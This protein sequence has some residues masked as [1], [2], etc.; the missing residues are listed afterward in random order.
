MGAGGRRRPRLRARATWPSGATGPTGRT[1]HR[2]A[3][4]V[5]A[6]DIRRVASAYL[7]EDGLTVGWSLPRRDGPVDGRPAR[8]DPH[9]GGDAAARPRRRSGRLAIEVPRGA[10]TL[11]DFRPRRSMLANGMRLLTERR[12]G[13]GVVALEL[14]VDAGQIRE[15]KPGLA[16]LTGRL[17]EEGTRPAT[18]DELAEA[19][20][21]AGGTL[22]VGPTGASLRVRAEDLDAGHR[23][24]RRPG[25]PARPSPTTRS[26]GSRRKV[27]AEYQ[28]DRDDPAFQADALFRSLV[29]GDHPLG[30]DPRGAARDIGR[31]GRDDVVDHHARYFV[32]GNAFLVAVGDFDPKA[33]GPAGQAPV[34]GLVGR[35]AAAAPTLPK[36]VRSPRPRVR[37]VAQAG[38]AGPPPARPPGGRPDH[39]DFD[40]L[41]RPRLHPRH[42]PGLH[43]PP[44]PGDPRRAG[45]GLLGRRRDDR[46][47]RP[48]AGALP[49]LRRHRPRRGRSRRRGRPGAGPRD[50]RGG[51]LR[52][53]GRDARRYL[54]GS[55]VFDFQ[56]V[57]QRAGRLLELE[58]WGLPLDEP[59]TWPGGSRRS[60]RARSAG[61][62][63]STSTPT[64]LVRV[65]YGPIRRG[66]QGTDAECA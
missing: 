34:R 32:P 11:V 35:G 65:E 53:G 42:G 5:E 33:L 27:A 15:A 14:Y 18:A 49:D 12:E 24:A 20:E 10:P 9:P 22:D 39:P 55:W 61:R 19:V 57:E 13:E 48:P 66:R 29:Y 60:P 36:L 26:N 45:P 16:Y 64:A 43:R 25:D 56:T 37:R 59:L 1:L 52:R 44:E 63:G 6:D 17:L 58:R 47:G 31:L 21:D 2:A 38:R 62:P 23:L 3:V 50:A 30:R 28:S 41:W 4:A 7:G 46:L 51:L 40:A 8:R 54:A